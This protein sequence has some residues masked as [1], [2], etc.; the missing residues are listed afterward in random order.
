MI[1]LASASPYR[2]KQL[3]RLGIDFRVHQLSTALCLRR[4]GT[5]FTHV[6]ESRLTMRKLSRGAIERY[7][8]RDHPLDC[9]GSY[10]IES[11]G[12]ALFERVETEDPSA[13]VGLPLFAL[14]RGLA[15]FGVYVP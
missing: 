10:K 12:A 15:R 14:V 11:L 2:A 9:A 7:V 13:I 3:E 6:D 8:K 5:E 4:G 1:V